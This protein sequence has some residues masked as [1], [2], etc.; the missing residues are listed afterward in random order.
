MTYDPEVARNRIHNRLIEANKKFF[1]FFSSKSCIVQRT[2]GKAKNFQAL[3]RTEP[4]TAWGI[5]AAGTYGKSQKVPLK[6]LSSNDLCFLYLAQD[7][8]SLKERVQWARV[9]KWQ[10]PQLC[11]SWNIWLVVVLLMIEL[12]EPTHSNPI[13]KQWMYK[14]E[15]IE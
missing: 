15:N 13:H 10:P 4:R 6:I 1:F 7:L 11:L 14:P 5:S 2:E 9:K 12:L 3:K 8:N